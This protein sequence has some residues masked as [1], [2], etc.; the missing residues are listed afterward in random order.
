MS[1]YHCELCQQKTEPIKVHSTRD[2]Q[3]VEML[4]YKGELAAKHLYLLLKGTRA[5]LSTDA[6]TN[7]ICPYTSDTSELTNKC[8]IAV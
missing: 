4:K 3:F 7:R 6:V 8:Q 5:K 1:L 2:Y